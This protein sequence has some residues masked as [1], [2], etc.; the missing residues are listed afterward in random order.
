M[1]HWRKTVAVTILVWSI[2]VPTSA[3]CPPHLARALNGF[4]PGDLILEG[5]P[6]ERFTLRGEVRD[7]DEQELPRNR[8]QYS[9]GNADAPWRKEAE[10]RIEKHRMADLRVVVKDSAGQ[11]VSG[12]DVRAKMTRH[13]FAFG[14]CVKT[15]LLAGDESEDARVYKEWILK[16]FNKA[17]FGNGLKWG[18]LEQPQFRARTEKSLEWLEA[19]NLPVRGHTLVWP[20]WKKQN[21]RDLPSLGPETL[22]ER[23]NAHIRRDAGHF[24]GRLAEWD[25][26]NEPRANR[27]FMKILGDEAMVE[28][29]QVARKAD[30]HA[31]LYLNDYGILGGNQRNVE[32]SF[33]IAQ[34]LLDNGAPLDGIG[35]QS[36]FGKDLPTPEKVLETLDRF[37]GFGLDMMVTEFDVDIKDEE[38]QAEFTRDFYTA[39]F[40]HPG[41]VGV[42]M[43]G[44]WEGRHWRPDGAM[45]RKD[46]TFKPNG[47]VYRDLVFDQWWTDEEGMTD[48]RGEFA[49]R[50]FLGAYEITVR[51]DGQ[52]RTFTAELTRDA[53]PIE[54]A[55]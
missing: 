41:I 38:T 5:D 22:R 8:V 4:F 55:L 25:V 14:S 24:A 49:T 1:A 47:E 44:F 39:V 9:G 2:V 40:S 15:E 35:F 18:P 52:S 26:I 45:V 20:G 32:K 48:D 13:A 17:V 51:R 50:G 19:N 36:H 31:K 16:L 43:W 10:A 42:M 11:P 21:P 53:A 27:D 29:F 12:A 33:G 46:W 30:R 3:Q 28:W 6:I 37:A 34:Y 7:V 23:I 54:A